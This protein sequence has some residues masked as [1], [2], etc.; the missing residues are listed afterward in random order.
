V[1]YL[2][3]LRTKKKNIDAVIKLLPYPI[4]KVTGSTIDNKPMINGITVCMKST[5]RQLNICYACI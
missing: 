3:K 4:T 5:R 2:Q 1:V